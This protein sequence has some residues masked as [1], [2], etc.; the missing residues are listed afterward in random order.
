M[1]IL[2]P[3]ELMYTDF[4]AWKD[5]RSFLGDGHG[6]SFE[7]RMW[8]MPPIDAPVMSDALALFTTPPSFPAIFDQAGSDDSTVMAGG[9]EGCGMCSGGASV[10]APVATPEP[11][12]WALMLLG[13][14][15]MLLV[16]AYGK[17]LA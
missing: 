7:Y 11:S 8:H 3:G 13:L 6:P 15:V 14:G 10:T 2:S 16:R 4:Y 9:D 1:I 5:W 17:R 12:T